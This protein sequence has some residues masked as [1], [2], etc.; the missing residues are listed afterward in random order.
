VIERVNFTKYIQLANPA[1]NQLGVL[2]AEIKDED[3]FHAEE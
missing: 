3:F 1:A 2:G